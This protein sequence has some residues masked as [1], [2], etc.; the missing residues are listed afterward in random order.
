MRII[1]LTNGRPTLEEVMGFASQGLVVLRKPNGEL[2]AL[3]QVDEF[4]VE[5]ELLKTNTEF[6][7]LLRKFAVDESPMSLEELRTELGQ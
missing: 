7:E 5:V 1:E 4:A 3:S 2:F 6:R